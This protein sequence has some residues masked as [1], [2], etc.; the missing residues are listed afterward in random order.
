MMLSG[1]DRK[2]SNSKQVTA[3][4]AASSNCTSP[5]TLA[6]SVRISS[7]YTPTPSA[8]ARYDHRGRYAGSHSLAM[9]RDSGE[10]SRALT[11]AAESPAAARRR[12]EYGDRSH[13]KDAHDAEN[14]QVGFEAQPI[15]EQEQIRLNGVDHHHRF[16]M[17]EAERQQL[18]MNV[19]LVRH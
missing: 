10:S 3:K 4:Q 1:L 6:V 7:A 16:V 2:T 14:R 8:T 9:K 18:V 5:L 19:I 15:G 13:K 17:I 12:L 11:G